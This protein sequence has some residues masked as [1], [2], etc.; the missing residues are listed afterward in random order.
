MKNSLSLV[1]L[2]VFITFLPIMVQ[3][4]AV[5]QQAPFPVNPSVSS[6]GIRG[7]L[8]PGPVQGNLGEMS[9]NSHNPGAQHWPQYQYPQHNNPFYDGG[10]PG[11]M[12]SETI[13]W[14]MALPSN[15]MDRFSEFMDTRVFPQKPATSGASTPQ[16]GNSN[17][18]AAQLPPASA[19]NPSGK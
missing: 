10:T 14:I 9:G 17:S 15:L 19:Y 5:T 13:D 3:A 8:E 6:Q 4:Q 7:H 11:G 18:P 2:A 12:V 16:S 1:G